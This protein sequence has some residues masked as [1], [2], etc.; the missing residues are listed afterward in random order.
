MIVEHMIDEPCC[1]TELKPPKWK[2]LSL[3]P[4]LMPT[5]D[6]YDD[7]LLSCRYGDLPD[8]QAFVATFSSAA[9]NDAVDDN[10]NSVLHMAAGNGHAGK[11]PPLARTPGDW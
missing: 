8:V 9:I 2:D 3:T 4:P 10:G 7:L 5:D 11:H 6:D 1:G